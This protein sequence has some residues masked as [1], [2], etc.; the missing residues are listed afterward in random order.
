MANNIKGITIEI[1]GNT[2]PLQKALEGVNKTSRDLQGELKEVEK[3]LKLDPTNTVLLEQKQKLLAESITNTSTKLETLKEAEKQVQQQFAKGEVSEEQYRALQRE[4]IKTE[5][6]LK[7]LNEQANETNETLSNEDAVE[8]LKNIGKAA[9][10][11]ALAV[12]TAATGVGTLAFKA[13]NDYEKALNS[14]IASTGM[15]DDSVS[16]FEETLQS[17][18]ANNYGESY[19]DIANAMALIYQQTGLTGEA[20]EETT[21]NAIIL[22][23]TFG[24][25]IN[26]SMRAAQML[27]K[28]FGMTSEEAFNLIAQGSQ[29]GLDKNGDLLD[30]INE[31]SVHFKQLGLDGEDMFNA[32]KMGAQD[33]AFSVDKV[34][35]AFKEFGIR[36]KDGSD[37]TKEA[38]KSLGINSTEM[39]KAFAAGGDEATKAYFK[40]YDALSAMKDPV[41]QNAAGVALF[42]SMWEDLGAKATLS[43]M[44]LADEFNGTIDTMEQIN[45]VKY[46]T[47][48]EALK[49]LGRVV[50]TDLMVPLG[51]SLMPTIEALIPK[52][53]LIIQGLMNLPQ[54]IQQNST[55]LTVL[56]IVIATI[57]ALVT[58][59][60]IQQALAV[61]EMT[62][63]GAVAGFGTTVTTA[64]GTAFTFLTSP[65]GLVILAIGAL[66]AIF[67]L[68]WNNCEGFRNFFI[69]LWESVKAIFSQV[70]EGYIIPFIQT[71]LVPIFQKAFQTIKDA[72]SGTFTAIKWLWDN[73]LGPLFKNVILPFI[74]NTLLPIWKTIFGGIGGAVSAAFSTI[75][76]LWNNSLK[77]IF[78]GILDFIS[79]VFTGNW[80][81]AWEGVKSIFSGVFEGL[82]TI[83][84][85]PINFI[86]GALNGFIRGINK[87]KIPDWVP[88][89]GGRGINIPMIPMLA[90][91]TDFFQGGYAIVGEQ[92]PE[93][94]KMPRG[95]QV[96]TN[97]ETENMLGGLSI[98]IENFVNNR[99]QDVQALAEEFEF[100][101]RQTAL[102]KGGN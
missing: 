40:V 50:E 14:I 64:L 52:I 55:L 5:Q 78:N 46:D 32:L 36:V 87:I 51:Q 34:G 92:G 61:S 68:L 63:W 88:G 10:G 67:V 54:W 26:E 66:I 3:Q 43:A 102:G 86:I 38:F 60:N 62:L 80:S 2:A 6:T 75:K 17:I 29:A 85:A 69:E 77:P 81:K 79:G 94:V 20:L 23:D 31:Y 100:Y 48:I 19:E 27:M 101:R 28:Q 74:Q 4:V 90:K 84:K 58:A 83:A 42:G 12:G 33:G 25:E 41:K 91:G 13:S 18:Y 39:T 21:T 9:A 98:N 71:Q 65:I 70:V 89:V 35:D 96:K 8:N 76:D 15:A 73:V 37:S 97:K 99:K 7:S 22:R 24:F 93:L 57:T 11:V 49:G 44:Q 72:V 56:G 16:G 47:P 1:G 82:K 53:Q 95:S 59:Y 30:S 45:E